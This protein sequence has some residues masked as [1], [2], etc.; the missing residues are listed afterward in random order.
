MRSAFADTMQAV[1]VKAD[2]LE[3]ITGARIESFITQ[4]MRDDGIPP[5]LRATRL[6]HRRHRNS[7]GGWWVVS[8][9]SA[10]QY[11]PFLLASSNEGPQPPRDLLVR[12]EE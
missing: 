8:H 12:I 2:F 3:Q 4:R 6:N 1:H 9:A 7:G 11:D 10:V 5:F